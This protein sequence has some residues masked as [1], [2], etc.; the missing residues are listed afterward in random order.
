[1]NLLITICARGGSKGIPGK[2]VKMLH[3][4]PLIAYTIAQA[5]RF[6]QS[7]HA[8][9][10]L[11]TDSEEIRSLAAD[12]GLQTEY[13]RP[14]EF[15]TDKAGKEAAMRNVLEYEERK[16]AKRYDMLLDLDVTSP[17]RTQEDLH[18]ALKIIH[19]D[20]K[21]LNLFSVNHAHRNPYFNMVEKVA[22]GYYRLVKIP[23]TPILSRQTAP[24]VF[25]LNASF[26]FFRRAFF[27]AGW[28]TPFS[29]RA[30]IYVMP[31]VCFDL[32]EPKD[33]LLL[34][35]LLD[36]KLLGFEL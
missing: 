33:F 21:A 17:L 24:Q 15:A 23:E 27:D 1:M 8:D 26:Y 35:Y 16:R 31:H 13:L 6:A 11:S 5:Q 3:G 14:H 12:C 20:P 10:A 22:D 30:L 34:E 18:E 36:K 19:A 7:H 9:V 28:K 29:D 25:D 32:D 4:K 2:N